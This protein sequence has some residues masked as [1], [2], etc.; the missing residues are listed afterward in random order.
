MMKR[1][2]VII[3]SREKNTIKKN[4]INKME[5]FCVQWKPM[6]VFLGKKEEFK[7]KTK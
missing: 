2:F 7:I 1:K 5:I 4:K 3:K 6:K